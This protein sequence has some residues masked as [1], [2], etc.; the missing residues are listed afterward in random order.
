M[1]INVDEMLTFKSR[2]RIFLYM[3]RRHMVGRWKL[4]IKGKESFGGELTFHEKVDSDEN[5]FK[6]CNKNDFLKSGRFSVK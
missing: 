3:H 5:E 4:T 2:I 6:D 1:L